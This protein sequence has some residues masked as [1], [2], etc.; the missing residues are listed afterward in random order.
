MHDLQNFM[1]ALVPYWQTLGF[2]LMKIEPGAQFLK[3][4]SGPISCK[5]TFCTGAYWLQFWTQPVRLLQSQKSI[6]PITP[7]LLIF[8]LRT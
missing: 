2:K 3:P 7:L 5:I 1:S 4:T 6:Q 8:R